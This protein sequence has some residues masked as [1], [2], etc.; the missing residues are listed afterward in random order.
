M[1]E[2]IPLCLDLD[3]T[4]VRTDTLFELILQRF[5]REP[6]LLF[7]M[8]FWL[9]RGKA[10]FKARLNEGTRIDPHALPW[11]EDLIEWAR[12]EAHSRP[13]LLV[14]AAHRNVAS[15][16]AKHLGFV[17]DVLA[18]DDINLKGQ[19]KADALV[20]RFGEQRFDYAGDDTADIPVWRVAREAIVVG[21][22]ARLLQ[23]VQRM[24]PVTR[25]FGH[26]PRGTELVRSWLRELRLYQWV[27]NLLLFL[28]P[29][30]AHVLLAPNVLGTAVLAFIVFGVAASGTYVMNDLLDLES[31]RRHPRKRLRP[32][33]AGRLRVAHGLV[34]GPAL[35]LLALAVATWIAPAFGG[36]LLLYVVVTT[37]YS[38]WMK[39][40]TFLDTAVLAGLYILRV[41][42][43]AAAVGIGL[44][45]WLLALCGYGFLGLALLKRYAELCA[46]EAE[47][48]ADA[49]GRGYGVR[50]LPVVLALGVGSSLVATLVMALYIDSPTSRT[51][52]AR[53]SVLWALVALMTLGVGRLWLKAGR[54][55]MHD[56]PILFVA[57]D[58][59]SIALVLLA[60]VAAAIAA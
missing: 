24:T 51:L 58:P 32:F 1:P 12:Q 25:V 8:P 57:K 6:L 53:P 17:H 44:S 5:K 45:F 37:A 55:H 14:T 54:G 39:R 21:A 19:R 7:R 16:V 35:M 42:A 46:L 11:R 29:A 28:A 22:P 41:V 50:D 56:D 20:R 9:V 49:A 18:T 30:A 34:A 15:T 36:L 40:K 52:Y 13:V 27:K 60:G 47:G 33:A 3:G 38:L 2:A 26:R 43:G 10:H 59:W 31:D 4:L 23:A 48:A